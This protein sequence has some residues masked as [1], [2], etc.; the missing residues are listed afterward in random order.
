MLRIINKY[1]PIVT[2]GSCN[3]W[4]VT[5]EMDENYEIRHVDISECYRLMLKADA[6]LE[7]S[8]TEVKTDW[9]TARSGFD[10]V[11]RNESCVSLN[12][13]EDNDNSLLLMRS[14]PHLSMSSI[15][16]DHF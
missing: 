7:E 12:R 4:E 13:V 5:K 2:M 6:G 3:T 8:W 9:G 1:S 10:Y 15:M 14:R 16:E 11:I